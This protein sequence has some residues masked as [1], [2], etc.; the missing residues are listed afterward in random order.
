MIAKLYLD[1]SIDLPYI[2]TGYDV[3]NCLQ[4]EIIAK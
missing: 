3:A 2:F 4:S 1:L